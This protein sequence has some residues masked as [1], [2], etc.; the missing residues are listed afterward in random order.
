MRLENARTDPS[1]TE[2]DS[3]RFCPSTCGVRIPSQLEAG[4]IC[5]NRG[6]P[7]PLRGYGET[8]FACGRLACSAGEAGLDEARRSRA[9]SGWEAGIRTP[10]TASRARCPTV[11]RPPS[12]EPKRRAEPLIIPAAHHEQQG[13]ALRTTAAVAAPDGQP[14]LPRRARRPATPSRTPSPHPMAGDRSCRSSPPPTTPRPR[15]P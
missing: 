10:I 1:G 15:R 2:L 3:A 11:E 8:D 4:T 9:K 7:P 6:P 13:D 12:E 14:G 5:R